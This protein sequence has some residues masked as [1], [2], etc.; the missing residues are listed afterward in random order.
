M[1]WHLSWHMKDDVR[2]VSWTVRGYRCSWRTNSM[3]KGPQAETIKGIIQGTSYLDEETDM[4][5]NNHEFIRTKWVEP[6]WEGKEPL[7]A[8]VARHWLVRRASWRRRYMIWILRNEWILPRQEKHSF[9]RAGGV[10]DTELPWTTS[11]YTHTQPLP[12]QVPL[13]LWP[14][15]LP[16]TPWLFL[17]LT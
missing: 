11:S 8:K 17:G 13:P 2:S 6:K 16:R 4:Q 10:R 3:C 12:G 15:C 1:K 7:K 5:T 14:P 9:Q